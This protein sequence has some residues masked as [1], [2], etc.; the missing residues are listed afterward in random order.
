[1]SDGFVFGL[2][3]ERYD[4][5]VAIHNQFG[6]RTEP[7]A[8][9]SPKRALNTL[10]DAQAAELGFRKTV[11]VIY[12]RDN[13]ASGAG[14]RNAMDGHLFSNFAAYAE[15]YYSACYDRCS[16]A[17]QNCTCTVWKGE[18]SLHDLENHTDRQVQTHEDGSGE[19]A[20]PHP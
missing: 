10:Q 14:I 1:M 4:G 2:R 6:I 12:E 3:T 8:P 11:E 15:D 19:S 17:C 20:Q 7:K 5:F 9:R 18:V 16:S 13:A